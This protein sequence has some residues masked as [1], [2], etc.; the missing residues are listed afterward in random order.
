MVPFA[1]EL[2]VSHY[3]EGWALEPTQ[4]THMHDKHTFLL[5]VEQDL[6][7]VQFPKNSAKDVR[8]T[9]EMPHE[10]RMFP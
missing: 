2:F 1:P 8:L 5:Y 3:L 10:C 4:Y 6:S 9:F 7:E